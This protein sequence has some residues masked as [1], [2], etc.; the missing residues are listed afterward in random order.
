MPYF[1]CFLAGSWMLVIGWYL[2]AIYTQNRSEKKEIPPATEEPGS[3]A[4]WERWR[5]P[6]TDGVAAD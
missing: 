3:S 2:G 4:V 6:T 1:E 5:V